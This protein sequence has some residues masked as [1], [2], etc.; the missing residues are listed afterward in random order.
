MEKSFIALIFSSLILTN[1]TSNSSM[2]DKNSQITH[3]NVQMYIKTGVTTKSDIIEKFGSPN[4]T[5]KDSSGKEVWT[6]QRSAQV[7]KSS[8][9]SSYLN[10]ILLGQSGDNTGFESSSRMVTL[11]IKFDNNDIVV[12][13]SSRTSNF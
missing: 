1:C 2:S 11:I 13:F 8:S 9:N 10:L 3:G 5:T 4:I 7:A 6:F 12:D